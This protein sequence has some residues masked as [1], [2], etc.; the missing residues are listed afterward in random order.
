MWASVI[1]RSV[2]AIITK[3]PSAPNDF[4]ALALIALSY[5]GAEFVGAWG[6]LAVFAAGLGLR[7]AEIKTVEENPIDED[8][9]TYDELVKLAAEKNLSKDDDENESSHTPAENIVDV[10][11]EE[12]AMEKPAV[13]AGLVVSRSHLIR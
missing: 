11:R 13:A 1:W 2:C 8:S 3:I 9:E 10:A 5:V 7:R 4:L 6:F 12:K